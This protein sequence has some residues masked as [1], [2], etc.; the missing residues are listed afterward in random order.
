MA[1][2]DNE[3]SEHGTPPQ[4]GP[5]PTP[6][7]EPVHESPRYAHQDEVDRLKATVDGLIQTVQQM[8]PTPDK[9]EAPTGKPWTHWGSRRS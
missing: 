5:P 3:N 8:A 6:E 4:D 9:D 2:E 1:D 7:P